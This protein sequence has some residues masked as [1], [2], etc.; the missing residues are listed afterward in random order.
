MGKHI[1]IQPSENT[2]NRTVLSAKWSTKAVGK[3]I[4]GRINNRIS[5]KTMA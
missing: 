5:L 2:F 4:S 3:S 1:P